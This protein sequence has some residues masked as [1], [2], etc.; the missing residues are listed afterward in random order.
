[1]VKSVFKALS[2]AL[3]LTVAM[4]CSRSSGST[5][6]RVQVEF[7]NSLNSLEKVT[8]S[9]EFIPLE[10][11]GAHLLGSTVDLNVVDGSYIVTDYLNGNIFRYSRDGR[12]LNSIGR[13]GNGPEEYVHINDVQICG[14]DLYVF[15]VPS[16]IQRFS[17]EGELLD[18]QTPENLD[19]G[20]MSWI[21]DEGI[22]TYYGYGSGRESRFSLL[23]DKART[24]Y[25][26]SAEKVM[27]YTP[28]EQI[29]SESGDSVFVVDSY[30]DIVKVYAGREMKDGPSFD[31]GKYTIPQTFYEYDDAFSAMESILGSEFAMLGRYVCDGDRRLVTVHLQDQDGAM[32]NYCGLFLSGRW[33][34]FLA[35]KEGSDVLSKAFQNLKDGVL[36]CLLDPAL[37]STFPSSLKS[38]AQNP[39]VLE[40]VSEE[41]NYI[42]AKI[43]LKVN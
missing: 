37:L 8:K 4:G 22:L 6:D 30:S 1:M 29:F 32:T 42:L 43:T 11:D 14:N 38:L 24:D 33:D 31:F 7:N 28:T 26:P 25:Y 15:S 18:T 9:V 39:E 3:L 40:S 17:L 2:C 12:F 16:K 35:G 13:R 23:S 36:Y 10:T 20:S 41:D 34:W 19:L 21:T 5:A 27:N